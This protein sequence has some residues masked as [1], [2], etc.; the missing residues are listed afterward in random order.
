MAGTTSIPDDVIDHLVALYG[1]HNP[2]T[3]RR[4][5]IRDL[6]GIA[7]EMC[8]RSISRSMVER[9][10]NPIRAERAQIAR[11]VARERITETLPK[12]LD[13]LDDMLTKVALD[14]TSAEDPEGRSK[15]LDSYHKGLALKMRFSG[16]GESV[17]VSGAVDLT[18]EGQRLNFFVPQKRSDDAAPAAPGP[19]PSRVATE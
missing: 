12:Q 4:T 8:G 15:A 18:S 7:T 5:T 10:I 14:F 2:K 11:E 19:D 6:T 3:G 16:V 13:A 1:A 17:D 9:V